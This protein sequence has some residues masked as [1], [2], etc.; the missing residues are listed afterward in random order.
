MIMSDFSSVER[1]YIAGCPVDSDNNLEDLSEKLCDNA[2]SRRG[3][4]VLGVNAAVAVEANYDP[5]YRQMLESVT[6]LPADGFW[7]SFA[8]KILRHGGVGHI[9]IERLVYRLLDR[10]SVSG[11]RVYLLGA[12]EEV[13]E[14]AVRVIE[15]RYKGI[16]VVGF[17]NGYFS[18]EDEETIAADVKRTD[19]N[20]VLVGMTSP[21][22][23]KWIS[24]NRGTLNNCV[25]IGVGGLFDV[26]AG[27]V[28]PAPEWIKR[29][30]FE[31]LFRLLHDPRRLWKRYAVGNTKFIWLVLRQA[32][33][34]LL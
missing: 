14:E 27:K 7:V 6:D 33:N 11:C 31:W 17:R 22:K 8:A 34:Q 5:I 30:G 29:S 2:M 26:F 13:V 10:L 28:P 32:R 15:A 4:Q 16:E 23:E 24:E 12:R 18:E 19:P 9:G 20:I 21:K 1:V 25:I 3:C